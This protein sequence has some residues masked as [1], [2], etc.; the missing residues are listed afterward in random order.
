MRKTLLLFFF[1]AF[2]LN[3]GQ[4]Q[5][6]VRDSSLL[7]T[8]ALLSPA[9]YT[10]DSPFY[11]LRP[12][13][14]GQPY[15]QSVT[16]FVPAQFSGFNIDSVAVALTGAISNLPTGVT[17]VCDPPSCRFRPQTLGCIRLTGTVAASSEVMPA[18]TGMTSAARARVWVAR[19]NTARPKT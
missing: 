5:N 13:C 10:P 7:I 18:G 1:A 3:A 14:L 2:L 6:C 12:A 16:V 9:P 8:G 19:P 15:N 4:A 11:N 17:Y